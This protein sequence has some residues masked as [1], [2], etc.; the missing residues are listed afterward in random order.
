M[1]ILTVVVDLDKGG[2]Q[3]AAQNFCEAYYTLGHDSKIVSVNGGGIR[4]EELE[5]ENIQVWVNLTPS[6]LNEISKWD[7]DVI[8]I[9]SH[10][11]NL[12]QVQILKR[13]CPHAKFVETN[14]FSNPTEYTH[15]L[16]YSY[17]LSDWC[18]YLY[19][20]RGGARKLSV[21]VPYPVKVN[22][23]YKASPEEVAE[24]KQKFKIPE[25]AF[26][27]GRIGQFFF[28]KWSLYLVDVFEQFLINV[29]SNSCLIVVNPPQEITDYIEERNLQDKVVII[30]RLYGD[31]ELRKCYS[32]IDVFLHIANQGESFGQVLAESLLCETPVITLNTPWDDNSQSEVVG[33]KIGGLCANTIK[34]FYQYM[35]QLYLNQDEKDVMG[36][37]GRIHIMENYDYLLV[38]Q[39][40]IELINKKN[41]NLAP[42]SSFNL[43]NLPPYYYSG[44]YPLLWMK[45][46]LRQHGIGNFLLKRFVNF[47]W[48]KGK[49]KKMKVGS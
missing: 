13:F 4:K 26:V 31:D 17:Q 20:S 21:K 15:F 8:H 41:S 25:N 22:N 40:S 34:E 48:K 1:K 37:R 47:Y 5:K 16:D 46:Y 44:A 45:M 9:H 2:T 42:I 49:S 18:E 43:K 27:F 32:A 29:K 10:D 36:K 38:A 6:N 33:D 11:V 24:F 12:N 3:R 19:L 7:P 14:V 39:K 30:D 23:F 35:L 28:G